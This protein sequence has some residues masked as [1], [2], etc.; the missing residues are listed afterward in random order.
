[1]DNNALEGFRDKNWLMQNIDVD[2]YRKE[3]KELL[4]KKIERIK[5]LHDD[6]VDL[7]ERLILEEQR[8]WDIEGD[9]D[10]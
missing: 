2:A 1:M 8:K 7:M 5:K 3:A 6:D 4:D 9:Q 10:H